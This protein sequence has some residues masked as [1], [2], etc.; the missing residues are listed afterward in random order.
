[1]Y[2]KDNSKY[3]KPTGVFLYIL[4]FD[5]QNDRSCEQPYQST[6]QLWLRH[7]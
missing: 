4:G 5:T 2:L 7:W 3:F 6:T 1:M